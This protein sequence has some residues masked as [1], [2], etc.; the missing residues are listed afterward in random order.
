MSAQTL[1]RLQE[2]FRRVFADPQLMIT[3]LTSAHD[4]SAWDSLNHMLLIT[5][6]EEQ[7]GLNFSFED[8]RPLQNVGDLV[9]L[10]DRKISC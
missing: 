9:Q 6:V 2:V 1:E 5:E 7:F 4:I 3:A 10:I 8:V